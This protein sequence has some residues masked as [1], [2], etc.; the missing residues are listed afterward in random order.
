MA[1]LKA[2]VRRD[3]LVKLAENRHVVINLPNGDTVNLCLQEGLILIVL[4]EED[5][6]PL[7]ASGLMSKN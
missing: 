2:T 5:Y 6:I 1:N 4:G 3:H 7:P